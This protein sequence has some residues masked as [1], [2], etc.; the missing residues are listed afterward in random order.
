MGTVTSLTER[1]QAR[2]TAAQPAP[3][4]VRCITDQDVLEWLE[5]MDSALDEFISD[6]SPADCQDVADV[7]GRSIELLATRRQP[8]LYAL[9][10]MAEKKPGE[11]P[12]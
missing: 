6:F 2:A 5:D 11:E 3:L 12:G 8:F 7:I 4:K 10:D 9:S 1:R